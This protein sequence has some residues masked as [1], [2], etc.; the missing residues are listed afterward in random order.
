MAAKMAEER[1]EEGDGRKGPAERDRHRIECPGVVGNATMDRV[2]VAAAVEMGEH[3]SQEHLWHDAQRLREVR[4][5][6]I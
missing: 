2:V 1:R 6:A 4:G 5:R 3:R